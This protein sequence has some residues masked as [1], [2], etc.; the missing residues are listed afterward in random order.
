[1]L[2]NE[3]ALI[4]PRRGISCRVEYLGPSARVMGMGVARVGT[5][6]E[7]CAG[8]MPADA[9]GAKLGNTRRGAIP[10]TRH[11]VNPVRAQF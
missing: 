3:L 8:R 6:M 7:R 9:V 11:P 10:R 2:L 1:V 4:Y 5:R